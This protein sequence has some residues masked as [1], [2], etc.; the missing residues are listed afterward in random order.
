MEIDA[1]TAGVKPGGLTNREQIKILICYI[2]KEVAEPVPADDIKEMLHFEGIA[3]YFEVSYLM[4]ELEKYGNIKGIVKEETFCYIVT[5]KGLDTATELQNRVPHTIKQF[6]V[7]QIKKILL[8][9]IYEKEN[10]VKIEPVDNSFIVSFSVMESNKELLTVRIPAPD[11]ACATKIKEMFLND[12]VN[13]Y[14]RITEII[15]GNLE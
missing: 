15:T 4:S 5:D 12:P 6:S 3:N 11:E 14:A 2:L 7:K 8:R 9:K 13:I 10:I 1:L